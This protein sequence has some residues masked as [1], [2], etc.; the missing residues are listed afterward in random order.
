MLKY[1]PDSNPQGCVPHPLSPA[2]LN[3]PPPP[4]NANSISSHPRGGKFK[5]HRRVCG[6]KSGS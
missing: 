5:T 4:A 6:D 2:A 3:P 1:L